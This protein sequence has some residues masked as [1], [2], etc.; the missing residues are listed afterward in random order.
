MDCFYINFNERNNPQ[1]DLPEF[2]T[3]YTHKAQF[4][5]FQTFSTRAQR[6]HETKKP[7]LPTKNGVNIRMQACRFWSLL[8]LPRILFTFM[9]QSQLIPGHAEEI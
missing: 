6:T 1:T 3:A 4:V 2:I 8:H 9:I 5:K 7:K